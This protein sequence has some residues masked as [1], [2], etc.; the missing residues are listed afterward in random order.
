MSEQAT[1]PT[2]TEPAS[3]SAAI[4]NL[5]SALDSIATNDLSIQPPKEEPKANPTQ[6]TPESAKPEEVK[7]EPEKAGSNEVEKTETNN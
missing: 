4:T 5:R 3:T 7:S 1:T 2:P 6:P